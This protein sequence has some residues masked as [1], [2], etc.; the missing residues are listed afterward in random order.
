[1]HV[2]LLLAHDV[3]ALVLDPCFQGTDVQRAAERLPCR[4]EWHDGFR[5]SVDELQSVACQ[6]DGTT[7]LPRAWD[8]LEVLVSMVGLA[9]GVKAGVPVEVGS[10]SVGGAFD[11]Q[12]VRAGGEPVDGGLGEQCV[13]HHREPLGGLAV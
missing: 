6:R 7:S 12:G 13:A 4:F 10:L 5:L 11:D 2:P 3:E 8:H 1:M 9:F